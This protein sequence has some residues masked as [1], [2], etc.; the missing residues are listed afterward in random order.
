MFAFTARK[1]RPPYYSA[2]ILLPKKYNK[3]YDLR[4]EGVIVAAIKLSTF[5]NSLKLKRINSNF[6]HR[7]NG[8]LFRRFNTVPRTWIKLRPA[9][10]V[11]NLKKYNQTSNTKK[12][13]YGKRY[14][15]VNINSYGTYNIMQNAQVLGFYRLNYTK[16]Y[17]LG[18]NINN[19]SGFKNLK[20]K[21]QGIVKNKILKQNFDLKLISLFENSVL[22]RN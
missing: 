3:I 17:S 2:G 1:Q 4:I 14:Q 15:E 16:L 6:L 9:W 8:V 22:L 18:K 5:R 19:L 21:Q 12:N 7:C 11:T 20:Q 13:K 10:A